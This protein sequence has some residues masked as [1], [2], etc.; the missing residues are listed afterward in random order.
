MS[1]P[2]INRASPALSPLTTSPALT[3]LRPWISFLPCLCLSFP[4]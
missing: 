1:L 3:S 4:F 2:D